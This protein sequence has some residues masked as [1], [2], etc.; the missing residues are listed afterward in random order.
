MASNYYNAL[1]SRRSRSSSP[2]QMPGM[3]DFGYL[4]LDEC[5]SHIQIALQ[6]DEGARANTTQLL[7]N[8]NLLKA[9][10][11]NLSLFFNIQT[12]DISCNYLDTLDPATICQMSRLR[13]LIAKDNLLDDKSIP[14]EFSANLSDL[15]V[16]NF[17][18]NL[19]TQFPYQ[20]LDMASLREIHLGS[21]KLT[22]LPRNYERLQ[23]LEVLYL[24]G[25]QLKSVPEEL[26]QLRNLSS[27][28]LS[29]NQI[30]S[31]PTNLAKMRR[32]KTLAL[33]NNNLTTL[34]TELVKLNLYEL[35]LRNNPLVT[36]FAREFTYN[37]PSLLE[38]CGRT[39][40]TKNVPY[41]TEKTGIILPKH[42]VSYLNSAQ[43][44]LNPKCKGKPQ[45]ALKLLRDQ[46]VF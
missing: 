20:L 44:C 15:E 12:L 10:P 24:G 30:S 5:N 9:L 4:E 2:Y 13:V 17:S 45:R 41:A 22:A 18:G 36:R 21:N 46:R 38:L 23:R 7:L 14:K 3:L 25:N 35:S 39:I 28:N 40:K 42:L 27:L 6:D 31:L 1:E 19:F 37:V 11:P 26:C 29:N 43:C 33:H 16:V 34:P 32:I 8:N